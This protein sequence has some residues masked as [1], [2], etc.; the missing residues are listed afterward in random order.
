M[1]EQ[2]LQ[3]LRTTFGYDGFRPPQ[4]QVIGALLNGQDALVLM[5][6]G[7]GKS[8]CYQLPALLLQGTGLVVS[9]LIALMQDQVQ[10]LLQ[11]G[12]RA[13]FLNSTL[14]PEQI[15]HTEDQ[16]RNGELD[17]LYIAPER[18]LQPRTLSLLESCLISLFAIDEAHCVSQ[19]G[20][21]FRPEYLK[22]SVLH[23]RFPHVPRIALTATADQRTRQ[24]IIQRL[25]LEQASIY[26]RGFDRPNIRYNIGPK[27]NARQQLL[28][29]L[30][31]DHQEDAGIVY[32]LSRKKVD[33]T[34]DWLCKQGWNALPYHAG[35]SAE[36][37][38]NNQH[39]FLT[40]ESVVIVATI[41]FGMG[42]DKP[43]VRFVA[44]LDLPKSIEAYYQETGRA[45]RDGEPADAWMVY[46]LQDVIFLRQMLENSDAADLQK[47]IERQR[48]EAML[49][50][51]EIT[52]C[53]RQSL[54]SYFGENEHDACGNC[55][56]CLSPVDT[57]DGT[58]AARKA[59][60]TVY[61]T[62]Q[63]FGVGHVIEVLLGKVNEKVQQYQHQQLST[64]GIGQELSQKEWRS[65]F[66]Q[67]IARGLLEVDMDGYGVLKLSESCRPVL[68]GEQKLQL[69]KDPIEPVAT[70][71]KLRI[72]S[73]QR[74]RGEDLQLW[75]D[76]RKLRRSL[77]VDQDVPPYVIFH[78][79]TLMEMVEHRPTSLTSLGQISGIG[80][81]KLELYGDAFVELLCQSESPPELSPIHQRFEC[82]SLAKAGMSIEQVA[83][84]R[85]ISKEQAYS[86]LAS[87]IKEDE[88]CFDEVIGLGG[89]DCESIEK[90]ILA[91]ESDKLLSLQSLYD[92][93]DG[94]Y[95]LGL[96]RC[97]KVELKRQGRL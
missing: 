59:L 43:N 5:P 75:E 46:G 15:R 54:L 16:L 1:L 20:H 57:W 85:Q 48:L 64:F 76:L 3:R 4:D 80:R 8:L 37:R 50:L 67:L 52:S 34:A 73:Q 47:Q 78:D 14:N 27:Q 29:F 88:V 10:A 18:L 9:P 93:L 35:L 13:A 24:E 11:L 87:A 33:E 66:R 84:Q 49:G 12:I 26:T 40:E 56:T 31:G 81:R 94:A 51:C 32:C 90:A 53:R 42:I 39:R 28:K 38:A 89:E 83:R 60:S 2:A 97:M 77:A 61:R 82:V 70:K 96:L 86:Y 44:H 7:G 21:D 58:E 91:P 45:G 79:A 72:S 92:L 36:L 25:A 62:G 17:L 63:R 23:E 71:R 19:W 22:L 30:K 74:F 95:P 55:D 6:T 69:R 65:L 68:K 41:A